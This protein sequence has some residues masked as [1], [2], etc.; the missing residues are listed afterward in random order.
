MPGEQRI[1][2]R[3]VVG[4]AILNISIIAIGVALLIGANIKIAENG[5]LRIN[6]KFAVE[7]DG[8]CLIERFLRTAAPPF[9]PDL[10]RA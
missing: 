10:T 6:G 3:W 8:A 2:G 7:S 5:P 4:R 9:F 1:V